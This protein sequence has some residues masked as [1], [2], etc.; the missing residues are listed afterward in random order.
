MAHGHFLQMGGFMLCSKDGSA[1]QALSFHEFNSRLKDGHIEFPSISEDEIRDRSK[2]DPLAKILALLQTAWFI[3]QCIA[4]GAQRLALTELELTTLALAVLNFVM[5]FLWWDKPFDVRCPVYLKDITEEAG[6]SSVK[7]SQG[8]NSAMRRGGISVLAAP[9]RRFANAVSH[10]ANEE[11]WLW[12]LMYVLFIW[13]L[14]APAAQLVTNSSGASSGKQRVPIFWAHYASGASGGYFLPTILVACAGCIFGAIHLIAWS[15][16]F[17]S[18]VEQ[19]LW[20]DSSLIVTAAPLIMAPLILAVDILPDDQAGTMILGVLL[21]LSCFLYILARL[22]LLVEAVI[23]LRALP[24][25]A[26]VTIQW[27]SYIPHIS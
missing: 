5:Y 8:G 7:D 15:F 13:P 11:G 12:A 19:M 1:L 23:S 24:A 4:R 20:R 10:K 2:R 3:V 27:I 6:L 22:A 26:Y 18:H 16:D 14:G 21:I 9:F 25:A 17:V